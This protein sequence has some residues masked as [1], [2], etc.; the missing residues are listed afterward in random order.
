MRDREMSTQQAINWVKTMQQIYVV[1]DIEDKMS[2]DLDRYF[3]TMQRNHDVGTAI[4]KASIDVASAIT[5]Y[6]DTVD[7]DFDK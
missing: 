1:Q 6:V 4:H 7:T 3:D 2:A 5:R